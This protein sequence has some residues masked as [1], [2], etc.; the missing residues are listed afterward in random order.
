MPRDFQILARYFGVPTRRDPLKAERA[1]SA[2]A[3][4]KAKRLAALHGVDIEREGPRAYWVTCNDKFTEDTDPM[5]GAN[6]C[7]DGR[8]VLEAVETYIEAMKKT[9]EAK[10]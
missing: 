3:H 5:N 10:Q 9:I 2:R 7:T 1:K 6:F 8:E 4:A